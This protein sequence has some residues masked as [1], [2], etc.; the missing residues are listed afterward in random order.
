MSSE[1]GMQVTLGTLCFGMATVVHYEVSVW[2]W[3]FLGLWWWLRAFVLR[4][5]ESKP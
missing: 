4:A 5:P 1:R 2:T 3:A